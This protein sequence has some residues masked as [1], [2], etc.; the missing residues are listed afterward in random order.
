MDKVTRVT[1]EQL[2]RLEEGK[3]YCFNGISF[4]ETDNMRATAYYVSKRHGKRVWKI[5]HRQKS[6]GDD[7]FDVELE[8]VKL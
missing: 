7:K 8:K 2:L 1:T 5:A 6:V 4:A 3:I